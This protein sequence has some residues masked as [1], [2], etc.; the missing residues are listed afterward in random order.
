MECRIPDFHMLPICGAGVFPSR[1]RP[2]LITTVTRGRKPVFRHF[3][4]GRLLVDE[5]RLSERDSL[6]ESSPG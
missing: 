2:Y 1:S 3:G 5:M 6:V 4:A